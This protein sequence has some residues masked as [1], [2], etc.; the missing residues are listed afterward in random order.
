[1]SFRL[2]QAMS[3]RLQGGKPAKLRA[4]FK[5]TCAKAGHVLLW[6]C[7]IGLFAIQGAYLHIAWMSRY[8]EPLPAKVSPQQES[9]YTLSPMHYLF[10]TQPLPEIYE[11]EE[12]TGEETADATDEQVQA[13]EPEAGDDEPLI[14]EEPDTTT[15]KEQTVDP[16]LKA[17]VQQALAELEEAAQE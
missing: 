6:G 5:R 1:M 12:K 13:E 11:P 8:P 3:S 4:P 2:H 7:W 15:D 10:K 16:A 9:D 14:N 17:R